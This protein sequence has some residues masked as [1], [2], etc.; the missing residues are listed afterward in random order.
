MKFLIVLLLFST[1][2]FA[3]SPWPSSQHVATTYILGENKTIQA[4]SWFQSQVSSMFKST[5]DGVALLT[6][7]PANSIVLSPAFAWYNFNSGLFIMYRESFY[8]LGSDPE[9]EPPKEVLQLMRKGRVTADDLKGPHW[10]HLMEWIETEEARCLLPNNKD[11]GVWTGCPD[12]WQGGLKD[13][14][15]AC[16]GEKTYVKCHIDCMEK[17]H[18]HKIDYQAGPCKLGETK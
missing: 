6:G 14:E 8:R 2:L 11:T 16:V 3:Q 7:Q 1:V 5:A 10:I 4:R 12:P 13:N 17:I 9:I 15:L 18:Q